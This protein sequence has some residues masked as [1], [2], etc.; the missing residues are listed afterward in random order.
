MAWRR[1]AVERDDSF[2]AG[3]DDDSPT[4]PEPVYLWRGDNAT[5]PWAA[6]HRAARRQ[7]RWVQDR[8]FV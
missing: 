4:E 1:E 7:R 6:F 5:L 3:W 2:D 8:V